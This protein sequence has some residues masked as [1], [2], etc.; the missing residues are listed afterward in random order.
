VEATS[1]SWR[2]AVTNAVRALPEREQRLI[3]LRFDLNGE[4]HSLATVGRQ[5]GIT[6]ERVRQLEREALAKLA[7]ELAV[8]FPGAIDPASDE[9]P[10][11]A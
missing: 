11:A 2:C 9:L 6:R 1:S 3:E 10:R 4:P 5:L 7:R 8:T